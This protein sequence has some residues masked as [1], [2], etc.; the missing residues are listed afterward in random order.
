MEQ[1]FRQF[2]HIKYVYESLLGNDPRNLEL[3]K[4][5]GVTF[6]DYFN[7][8]LDSNMT[9]LLKGKYVYE[10][11][12]TVENQNKWIDLKDENKSTPIFIISSFNH[13]KIPYQEILDEN[14]YLTEILIAGGDK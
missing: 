3:E 1:Q 8:I 11:S 10:Q 9:L 12:N 2:K 13:E 14:A 5:L 4:T 7:N 6:E